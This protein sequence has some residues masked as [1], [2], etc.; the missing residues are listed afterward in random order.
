MR[1]VVYDGNDYQVVDD[2]SV[3]DPGPGEVPCASRP[4]GC[5]TATCR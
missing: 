4:P 3:R 5:A 1:G 2:L